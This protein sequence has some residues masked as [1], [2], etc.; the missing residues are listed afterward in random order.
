MARK[1]GGH[2]HMYVHE[3][4]QAEGVGR[5]GVLAFGLASVYMCDVFFK[6]NMCDV[7]HKK[8]IFFR[9]KK[10]KMILLSFDEITLIAKLVI[11]PI[12]IVKI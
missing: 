10:Q 11:Q 8:M 12:F 9:L 4:G 2:R 5:A 3:R 6:K 7:F 1:D